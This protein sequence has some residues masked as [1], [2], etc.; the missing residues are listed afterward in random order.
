[1]SYWTTTEKKTDDCLSCG[2]KV[3][4]LSGW[5]GV[6]SA[7]IKSETPIAKEMTRRA[8]RR[9]RE[10]FDIP[11]SV[12]K[13]AGG[14]ECRY[15]A[16]RCIMS[17][18]ERGYCY[19]RRNEGDKIVGGGPAGALVSWYH[20]PLP[21]NCVADWVCPGGTG[22]GFP[23]FAHTDGPEGGYKNLA[24][25]YEA[26]NFDCL[27]CQNWHFRSYEKEKKPRS[28]EAL[29]A[30]A[31][32]KTSCI[33]YFGGDPAPQ[34]PHA[35]RASKRARE[36]RGGEI[37][38]I[39]WETN[40]IMSEPLLK[41]AMA[42]SLESGGCIK[43][44]LKAWNRG[45]HEAL[46]GRGNEEV[47]RNFKTASRMLAERNE[48]PTLVASTLLVPG[49]I[50]EEEVAAIARFIASVDRGIPYALLAFHPQFFMSDLPVT[51]RD[52]A[53]RCYEAALS[54]GLTRVRL[55][56]QHLFGLS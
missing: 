17:E 21:T 39:C 29:A 16:N 43:F 25:F 47:F 42:L 49:Y 40:G 51:S 6:C 9:G 35:I 36:E 52:L 30:A 18:G 48:P 4:I 55:G 33:C 22:A 24:V 1:M 10:R 12:P 34:M 14:T 11:P 28:A 53:Y 44:D 41:Q 15:C 45:I 54:E 3:E 7:C 31:D 19:V 23:D 5:L 50:D 38:R 26:C 37:L 20:D 13:E 46:C 8:H 32:E 2:I 56:N 27:F